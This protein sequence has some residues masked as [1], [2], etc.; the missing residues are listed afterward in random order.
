MTKSKI[1]QAGIAILMMFSMVACKR[2]G[3]PPDNVKV[4]VPAPEVQ[5]PPADDK[6]PTYVKDL[7]KDM[8]KA[9]DVGAVEQK[10]ADEEKKASDDATK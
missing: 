1:V 2:S 8:Q 4:E 3:P 9:R 5:A 10:S 7:R 6:S